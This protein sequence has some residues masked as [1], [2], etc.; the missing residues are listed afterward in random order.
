MTFPSR[1]Q[2]AQKISTSPARSHVGPGTVVVID[3]CGALRQG[4]EAYDKKV[5]GVIS[6]AG[7]YKPG[8]VLGKQPSEGPRMP[9]SFGR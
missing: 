4:Y 5:A 9:V 2:I 6:G 3:E 1:I 7:D 8:I